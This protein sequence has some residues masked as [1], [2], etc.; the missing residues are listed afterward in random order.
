MESRSS[1]SAKG[2]RPRNEAERFWRFV[3]KTADCWNWTGAIRNGYGV[4]GIRQSSL[5]RYAHRLSYEMHIGSVPDGLCVC[6]RCDNKR[7]VNPAHFYLDSHEGNTRDAG[8]KG[9]MRGWSRRKGAKKKHV[10]A[11]YGIKVVEIRRR[12]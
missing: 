11:Q 7:C 10:E 5:V 2:P 3:D 9:M 4:I 12:G 6:H 1:K 8:A